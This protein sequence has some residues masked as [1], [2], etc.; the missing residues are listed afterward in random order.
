MSQLVRTG[1]VL[2]GIAA[3]SVLGGLVA[4]AALGMSA[5]ETGH[6]A[7]L[8][9]P[10]GLATLVAAVVAARA[11]AGASLQTRLVAVALVAIVVALANLAV[12]AMDMVVSGDDAKRL[13]ILQVYALG[14][15]VAVAVALSRTIGPSFHTFV[16]SGSHTI[17]RTSIATVEPPPTRG[18]TSPTTVPIR[19][20]SHR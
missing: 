20:F 4:S 9:V 8:L 18:R 10:A 5:S 13:A 3:V 12:L 16:S 2:A 14:A 19:S 6:V 15:G 11:L 17:S 1:L 7:A